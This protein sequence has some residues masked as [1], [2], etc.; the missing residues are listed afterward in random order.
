MATNTPNLNL[1]KPEMSDYADIR[2]LNGNMD[3]LDKEVGG[4][5][6]VK[7]VTK[8]D[9]GLT[10]TKKDDTEV[11]VPFN[12]LPIEGGNL[13][14]D[15]TIQNKSVVYPVEVVDK[16]EA[17]NVFNTTRNENN[18]IDINGDYYK[19]VKYSDGTMTLDAC[20]SMQYNEIGGYSK[21]I[22]FPIPF[23][24]NK[25]FVLCSSLDQNEDG[26]YC[27]YVTARVSATSMYIYNNYNAE[28][29]L[30]VHIEGSW[31]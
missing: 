3:I 30:M 16:R 25:L 6:Y 7:D 13:T 18:Q 24:N 31:K 1:V 5:N 20:Y 11:K 14:G 23:F 12:Y 28:D 15:L 9:E 2:V 29:R 19:I 27:N 10:F 26:Y 21:P 8:S 17:T 4:L 22:T